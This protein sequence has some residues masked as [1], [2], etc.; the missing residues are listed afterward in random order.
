[1]RRRKNGSMT[2]LL[3]AR[4]QKVRKMVEQIEQVTD[5]LQERLNKAVGRAWWLWARI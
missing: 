5:R 1:M 3:A 2:Q 4:S